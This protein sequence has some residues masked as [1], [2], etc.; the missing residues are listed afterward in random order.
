MMARVHVTM[1]GIPR[2]SA[3]ALLLVLFPVF[4]ALAGENFVRNEAP[5]FPVPQADRALV[6]IVRPA[7][8]HLIPNPTFEVFVDD[9]PAGY[10]PQRSYLAA[11]LEPGRRRVW[12]PHANEPRSFDFESGNTYVL[13]LIE[14]YGPNRIVTRTAWESGD[15]A[16]VRGLVEKA[17][18]SHVTTTES[19]MLKLEQEAGAAKRDAAQAAPANAQPIVLPATFATVWYRSGDRAA[20]LKSYDSSGVLTVNADTIRFES[21]KKTFEIPNA[22]IQSVALDKM[23]NNPFDPNQWGI[24][25][26]G[27]GSAG[28]AAFK[29]GHGLG[30]GMDTERIYQALS[31][32]ADAARR[33]VPSVARAADVVPAGFIRYQA[34]QNQFTMIIPEDWMAYD[35]SQAMKGVPGRFG[36]I[37]FMPSTDFVL[38]PEGNGRTA[39]MEVVIGLSGGE[40]P[41]FFVQRQAAGDGMSCS[42]FSE[43]A[44]KG[45][46]RLIADEEL[47]GKAAEIAQ[48]P[49]AEPT[50]V[51]GCRGLKLYGSARPA[52]GS[53][54]IVRTYAV[55]DGEMLYLFALRNL[56]EYYVRNSPVFEQIVA[57][58]E[59]PLAH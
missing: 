26:F 5:D 45:I 49:Q 35:Q 20:S 28:V 23:T 59:L 44:T 2:Y 37:F 30:H 46:L 39:S 10:L 38:D 25:R 24:V 1:N 41:S 56:A 48:A 9:R 31:A 6:Y 12:G 32:A 55:S 15:P 3:C 7:F 52:G 50:E 36:L 19:G 21:K 29:D 22:T 42:G 40:I 14:S 8:V 18:L 34:F 54:W 43:K 33:A 4:A 13:L 17:K 27:D 53:Q 47:F 51:A 16:D 11:Q 57:T 58:A